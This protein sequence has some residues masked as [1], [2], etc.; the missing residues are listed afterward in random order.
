MNLLFENK[1]PVVEGLLN[2]LMRNLNVS[3][4]WYITN[5]SYSS[6]FQLNFIHAVVLKSVGGNE[7]HDS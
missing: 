4:L 1:Y 2:S 7:V 6:L 3:L 5:Q